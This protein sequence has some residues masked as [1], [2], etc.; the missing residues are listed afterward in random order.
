M[1]L[2]DNNVKADARAAASAAGTLN[3][4]RGR[5]RAKHLTV[6]ICL[7]SRARG[8]RAFGRPRPRRWCALQTTHGTHWERSARVGLYAQAKVDIVWLS[9]AVG[10]RQRVR[11]ACQCYAH[12]PGHRGPSASP[13]H[14]FRDQAGPRL[15]SSL[16][17][18]KSCRLACALVCRPTMHFPMKL[19]VDGCSRR[20]CQVKVNANLGERLHGLPVC[21]SLNR[22]LPC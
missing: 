22:S 4:H 7:R 20:A 9:A 18:P 1:H 17:N 8:R 6:V 3:R 19:S 5:L 11:V 15:P 10:G 12:A 14:G 16:A 2:Q 21:L 13:R